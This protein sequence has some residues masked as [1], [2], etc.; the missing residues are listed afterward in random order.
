M[1]QFKHAGQL[2]FQGNVIC[3]LPL[4]CAGVH[5]QSDMVQQLAGRC[6]TE[7]KPI[8]FFFFFL[9]IWPRVDPD[10]VSVSSP[11]KK[12]RKSG[13][14]RQESDALAFGVTGAA[15]GQP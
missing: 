10:A 11:Q 8:D 13:R 4:T 9:P 2:L 7:E 1:E 6:E 14:K 3:P 15:G 12:E 5:V